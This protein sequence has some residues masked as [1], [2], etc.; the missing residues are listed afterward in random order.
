LTAADFHRF[1]LYVAGTATNSTQALGNLTAL[2]ESH[3]AGRHAIEE[4]DVFLDP[5]RAL[6]DGIFMTPTLVRL[7]PPPMRTIVG[8]LSRTPEVLAALG[9]ADGAL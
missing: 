8:N 4:V 1:R 9:L 7:E 3:L 5:R 6:A 2:C